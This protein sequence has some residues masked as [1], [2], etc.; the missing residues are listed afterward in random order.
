MLNLMGMLASP[1]VKARKKATTSH[2]R[3]PGYSSVGLYR[4]RL[5]GQV[6]TAIELATKMGISK[7]AVH[8]WLAEHEF[9]HVKR[10]AVTSPT[11]KGRPRTTWTWI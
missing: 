8:K 3:K 11:S 9:I 5:E 7:Q 1:P 10:V 6:V 4:L 2:P